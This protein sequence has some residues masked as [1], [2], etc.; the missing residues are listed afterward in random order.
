MHKRH[1]GTRTHRRPAV[2]GALRGCLALVSRHP[3]A[4]PPPQQPDPPHPAPQQ[5]LPAPDE[6]A[7]VELM[8]TCVSHVFIRAL[9]AADRQLALRLLAAAMRGY[10]DALLGANLDLLEY[11]ISSGGWVLRHWKVADVRRLLGVLLGGVSSA[12]G[13]LAC[14]PTLLHP[15]LTGAHSCPQQTARMIL[16]HSTVHHPPLSAIPHMCPTTP[17][18]PLAV[19]G[20]KDP[21]CLLLSF[22]A[23]QALLQLYHCQPEEALSRERLEVRRRRGPGD[24]AWRGDSLCAC[25]RAAS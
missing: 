10:G 11:G 3:A 9:A 16:M 7:A 2:R 20:E 21:R 13:Q 5:Q 1:S 6:A 18:L 19:D 17:A 14:P 15:T 8:R 25:V 12:V 23:I 24:A 4:L 22:E